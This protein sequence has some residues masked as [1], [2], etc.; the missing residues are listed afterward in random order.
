MTLK[1]VHMPGIYCSAVI[2]EIVD[3][4]KSFYYR[5]GISKVSP[6]QLLKTKKSCPPL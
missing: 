5:V 6:T 3:V 1:E 4:V 2:M